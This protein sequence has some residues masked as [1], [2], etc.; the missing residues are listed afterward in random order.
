MV[1]RDGDIRWVRK[2]ARTL[3]EDIEG[4]RRPVRTIGAVADITERKRAE[5]ELRIA[6]TAFESREGLVITDAHG[7]ILR[8]NHAF[9]ELTGY[10]AEEAIGSSPSMLK[11]ARHDEQF[12]RQM[13]QAIERDGHWQ[14]EIW[15]RRKNGEEFPEWLLVTSVKNAEGEITH[16]VG[17]FSDISDQKA[18]EEEIRKLAF[19]DPL[20]K[21]PN[22]RLL[23]DRLRH[24]LDVSA[25]NDICGAVLFIDLDN[26]KSL[27]DTKG[28]AVGDELLLEVS[29]RLQSAVRSDDLVARLGGDEFLI[30]LDQLHEERTQAAAAARL[31]A[32]KALAIL[33]QPF[34]LAGHEHVSS[35]SIGITVFHGSEDPLEDLLRR[36]DTAMYEAKKAGRNTLRFFDPGMQAAL[37]ERALIE[38]SMRHGLTNN[39]FALHYQV[40]VDWHGQVFGAEALLRWHHPERGLIAPDRFVPLA[41]ESGFILL[42]GHWVIET[43]CFTLHAWQSMPSLNRLTVAVNVS[44]QQFLQG[45]FVD[46]VRSCVARHGIDPSKLKLELTESL[47][48]HNVEEAIAK[49]QQLKSLGIVFSMD[50]FGTGHSSLSYLK[51]L[52]LDQLKIDRSFVRDIATDPSDAI[53][54]QTI[55]SMGRTLGLEVIAEGVESEDQLEL[56]RQYGCN[57][58]QGYLFGAPLPAKDLERRMTESRDG[59]DRNEHVGP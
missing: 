34:L 58:Y 39:E 13:W 12:Y 9:E 7:L 55:I 51:R 44:A 53:I 1:R 47:V 18:A 14:G 15:N 23:I 11:S 52:P 17:S 42:L 3:F 6:A 59:A 38:R 40:Q 57:A 24:A 36:S 41:E 35:A 43:A 25:K 20:T 26:F 49:M 30:L 22:R 50:D 28:H 21:L 8:V 32:D 19:F 31:V 4:A 45:D 46:Q 29:R 27:N 10:S 37:E 33:R 16:Y 54:V 48:L 5:Q 2:R 56:L